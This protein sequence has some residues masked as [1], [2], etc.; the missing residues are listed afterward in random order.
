MFFFL[1]SCTFIENT[2]T[3]NCLQELDSIE[4]RR[5]DVEL[6]TRRIGR[7][8]VYVFVLYL[9]IGLGAYW[10]WLPNT[11]NDWLGFLLPFAVFPPLVMFVKRLLNWYYGRQLRSSRGKVRAIFLWCKLSIFH[12]IAIYYKF[13]NY[14]KFR[15]WKFLSLI[16]IEQ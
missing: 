3:I 4:D 10:Y 16:Y 1:L 14:Q 7:Y 2:S 11:L 6:R 15:S 13:Y 5:R 8:V 12:W 9:V